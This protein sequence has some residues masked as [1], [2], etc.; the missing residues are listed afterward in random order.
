MANKPLCCMICV[1]SLL[2]LL[3]VA[4]RFSVDRASS[5]SGFDPCWKL[6]PDN[7]RVLI[8]DSYSAGPSEL[9]WRLLFRYV[10]A[11]G[12]SNAVHQGAS[13]SSQFIL[14][15]FAICPLIN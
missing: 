1:G 2:K 5:I 10:L 9:L 15:C 7:V 8:K 12:T 13:A 11:L 4:V 14:N 6:L 3:Q